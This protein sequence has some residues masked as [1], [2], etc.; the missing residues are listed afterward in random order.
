MN[1]PIVKRGP[2]AGVSVSNTLPAAPV[3]DAPKLSITIALGSSA[4][5]WSFT[6][7]ERIAPPDPTTITDEVS[8]V[9]PGAA[10]ASASGRPI[11]SP[12]T[13]TELQRSRST[14]RQMRSGSKWRSQLS[15]TVPPP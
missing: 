1:S 14:V 2:A 6:A 8:Y 11:A 3:S 15:T 10:R 9:A 7:G 12:T 4:R 5:S 13:I